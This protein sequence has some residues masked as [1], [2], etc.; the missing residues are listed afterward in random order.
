ML[1]GILCGEVQN[2]AVKAFAAQ[3]GQQLEAV[4]SWHH[5]IEDVCVWTELTSNLQG[6]IAIVGG[7]HCEALEFKAYGEQLD[8]VWL[9]INDEY[10]DLSVRLVVHFYLFHWCPLAE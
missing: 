5:D 8:D 2:W 7:H 1:H 10:A 3:L 6:F 4:H 9:V